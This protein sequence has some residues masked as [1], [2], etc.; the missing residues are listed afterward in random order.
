MQIIQLDT[1]IYVGPQIWA[2]DMAT[3]NR[4]KIGTIIV[5]RPEGETADQP[6]ISAIRE[7]ADTFG[8]AIHQLPIVPGNIT[9][10]DVRAYSA[11]TTK[12]EGPVLA[13]CRSG[14][15]AASLWALGAARQGQ[16]PDEI[17]RIA[18]NANFDLSA[19]APRLA[20]NVA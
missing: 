7:A 3:L 4:M 9:D 1:Q 17:L 6:T 10:D 20:A 18:T 14:M 13:Y 8:I 19:L 16:T 15:R 12:A 5:A 11:I 2:S